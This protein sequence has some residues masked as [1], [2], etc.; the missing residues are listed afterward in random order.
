MTSPIKADG[1]STHPAAQQRKPD[2]ESPA[3]VGADPAARR[4]PAGDRTEVARARQRLAHEAGPVD[5]PRIE[6]LRQA[7][8]RI[9]EL[10]SQLRADPQAALSAHRDV[11]GDLFAAAMARPVI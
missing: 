6:S 2:A 4:G 7:R 8:E 11:S 3:Q 10:K 1:F 9:E 5:V